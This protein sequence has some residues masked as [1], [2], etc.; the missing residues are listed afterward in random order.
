MV[1]KALQHGE[2]LDKMYKILTDK[3]KEAGHEYVHEYKAKIL[4]T[5]YFWGKQVFPRVSS[6][7]NINLIKE[8]LDLLSTVPSSTD[9]FTAE[10]CKYTLLF[11]IILL[12]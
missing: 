3:A 8:N 12:Y 7:N 11:I 2:E 10:T 9:N 6:N 1:N 4:L 5:E